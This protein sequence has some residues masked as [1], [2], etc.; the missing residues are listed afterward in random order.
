MNSPVR[1]AH[2]HIRWRIRVAADEMTC[3]ACGETA[4][5]SGD[6]HGHRRVYCLRCHE[7]GEAVDTGGLVPTLSYLRAGEWETT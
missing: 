2:G 4:V 6:A 7:D 5:W 1:D 3:T